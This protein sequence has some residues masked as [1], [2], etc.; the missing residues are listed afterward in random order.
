MKEV[1]FSYGELMRNPRDKGARARAVLGLAAVGKTTE[2]EKL[3]A[4]C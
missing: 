4:M 3:L 1:K 2:A